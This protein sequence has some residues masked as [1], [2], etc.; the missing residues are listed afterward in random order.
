M[1]GIRYDE[2]LTTMGLEKNEQSHEINILNCKGD[3]TI[4][5]RVVFPAQFMKNPQFMIFLQDLERN[6]HLVKSNYIVYGDRSS[7]QFSVYFHIHKCGGTTMEYM[8]TKHVQKE[9]LNWKT[10]QEIGTLAFNDNILNLLEDIDDKVATLFSFCR[11]PVIRFLSSLGQLLSMKQ[12]HHKLAPCTD[13]HKRSVRKLVSC[14]LDKITDSSDY[15]N[16][17]DPHFMPQI[18][19]LYSAVQG[20]SEIRIQLFALSSLDNLQRCCS[21]D[22]ESS[23]SANPS[24]YRVAQH[25]PGFPKLSV[26]SLTPQLIDRICQVYVMDVLFLQYLGG[27][28]STLCQSS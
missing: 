1:S 27:L 25:V 28:E 24:R 14:V 20:K 11:D 5:N 23:T 6:N 26:H 16:Y 12:R 2:D 18:Y 10:E 15:R 19:E 4:S 22:D 7:K 17:L 3:T 21:I 9:D 13:L 8:S